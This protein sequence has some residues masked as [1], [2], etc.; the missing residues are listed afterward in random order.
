MTT[1]TEQLNQLESELTSLKERFAGEATYSESTLQHLLDRAKE[2]HPSTELFN[3]EGARVMASLLQQ[4][5]SEAYTYTDHEAAALLSP[6]GSIR[7]QLVKPP[8]MLRPEYAAIEQTV[9]E[10]YQSDIDAL[11]P[12]LIAEIASLQLTIKELQAQ[13]KAEA[14]RETE[15]QKMLA[16]VSAE[17]CPVETP[18]QLNNTDSDHESES[19]ENN[20]D[21]E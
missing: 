7:L 3:C 6:S 14:K 17:L 21:N 2:L 15:F 1:S 9:R 13:I 5:I 20:K 8:V 10:K 16:S 12:E 11:R 4:K 19:T 18:P